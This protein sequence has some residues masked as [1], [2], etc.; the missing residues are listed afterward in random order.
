MSLEKYQ[1]GVKNRVKIAN[2]CRELGIIHISLLE[3][4]RK[5]KIRL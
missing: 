2:I 4:M 5:I 1:E 3:F